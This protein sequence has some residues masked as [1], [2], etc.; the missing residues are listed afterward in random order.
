MLKKPRQPY[1]LRIVGGLIVRCI[2]FPKVLEPFEMQIS[3][4]KIYT[5]VAVFI[6]YDNSDCSMSERYVLFLNN[7]I[8]PHRTN[9]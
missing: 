8:L 7:G 1:N 5:Q 2:L 6:S 9:S 3:L 4:F